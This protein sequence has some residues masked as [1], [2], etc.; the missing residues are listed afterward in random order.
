V[1]QNFDILKIKEGFI[2]NDQEELFLLKRENR[3]TQSD[4]RI[5]DFMK[6]STTEAIAVMENVLE[7][8]K[9]ISFPITPER[10]LK[11]YKDM[12]LFELYLILE[13]FSIGLNDSKNN[14]T[15]EY[16]E[17]SKKT[18]YLL[19]EFIYEKLKKDN[20]ERKKFIRKII[21][22]KL[23]SNKIVQFDSRLPSWIF[24]LELS[25]LNNT[26]GL[27]FKRLEIENLLTGVRKKILYKKYDVEY[28]KEI[29]YSMKKVI[30]DKNPYR[31]PNA[32][33]YTDFLDISLFLIF[34]NN[35]FE[36]IKEKIMEFRLPRTFYMKIPVMIL[37][38]LSD[39]T[40]IQ[41]YKNLNEENTN[42]ICNLLFEMIKR[43]ISP[44]NMGSSI[45]YNLNQY[46]LFE[47]PVWPYY[48]ENEIRAL[49]FKIL[50]QSPRKENIIEAIV[51]LGIYTDSTHF[52]RNR[53]YLMNL[54]L[55]EEFGK[56][57]ET[58]L[59]NIY[60]VNF[61]IDYFKIYYQTIIQSDKFY[62]Y[63]KGSDNVFANV[64]SSSDI[65]TLTL[66]AFLSDASKLNI[67]FNVLLKNGGCNPEK[68]SDELLNEVFTYGIKTIPGPASTS[69]K[70]RFIRIFSSLLHRSNSS[71]DERTIKLFFKNLSEI[72]IRKT[73]LEKMFGM[74]EITSQNRYILYDANFE[75]RS[76]LTKTKYFGLEYFSLV[77]IINNLNVH[78]AIKS[79]ILRLALE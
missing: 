3:D 48:Y 74:P 72:R 68:L 54:L 10:F 2:V 14:I 17:Y 31:S 13:E 45:I 61:S 7:I 55:E 5:S 66:G 42:I 19:E 28:I 21:K 15:Y 58:I 18:L 69:E 4:V 79:V 63:N 71:T 9:F 49:I 11:I 1:N 73:V 26:L 37:D 8:S 16:R 75:V 24:N 23:T 64:L 39:E 76:S 51:E 50:E 40:L 32:F 60:N 20:I 59:R 53:Y 78:S 36:S 67:M 46:L 22:E 52:N 6:V 62:Y 29:F 12:D 65:R 43:N 44:E 35:N 77:P 70:R 57:F 56:K 34:E 47:T 41:I 27:E 33:N 25:L 38:G 30:I